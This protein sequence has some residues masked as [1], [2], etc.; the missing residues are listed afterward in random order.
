MSQMTK[1]IRQQIQDVR[2]GRSNCIDLSPSRGG[3]SLKGIPPEIFSLTQL[4]SLN[5]SN[6]EIRVVP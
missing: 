6:N 5:L 1:D 2:A 4:E 3:G